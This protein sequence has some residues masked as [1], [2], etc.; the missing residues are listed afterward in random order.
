MP[1]FK[2]TSRYQITNPSDPTRWRDLTV[3]GA[4]GD[5]V[6]RQVG[7]R[8][9]VFR[10]LIPKGRH[11]FG[12][13]FPMFGRER[14]DMDSSW[15]AGGTLPRAEVGIVHQIGVGVIPVVG[16]RRTD[17]EDL[18]KVLSNAYLEVSVN[19]DP[20]VEGSLETLPTGFGVHG[21]PVLNNGFP[22]SDAVPDRVPFLF[23]N[24]AMEFSGK[25]SFPNRPWLREALAE[26]EGAARPSGGSGG[27]GRDPDERDPDERECGDPS[28]ADVDA[29]LCVTLST[30]VLVT[31]YMTGGFGRVVEPNE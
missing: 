7:E 23:T 24:E 13:E 22:A 14:S 26:G 1:E 2:A 15:S 12:A 20:L 17:P 3:E 29:T 8:T 28:H 4:E 19:D 21:V 18:L 27:G 9:K 10:V 5:F 11:D 6:V 31:F 16:D 30:D 25:L